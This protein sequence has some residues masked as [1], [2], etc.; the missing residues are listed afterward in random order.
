MEISWKCAKKRLD[1]FHLKM[2]KLLMQ[3]Y[4]GLHISYAYKYMVICIQIDLVSGTMLFVL[5]IG[6]I[7][8]TS[9]HCALIR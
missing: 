1:K 9:W 8:K 6:R 2:N 5:Q 3:I 4:L 7:T